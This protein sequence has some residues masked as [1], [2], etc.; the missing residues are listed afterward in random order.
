MASGEDKLESFFREA[1]KTHPL[2]RL[3]N[4]LDNE[5]AGAVFVRN[6]ESGL[7]W[8][9]KDQLLR[10][11]W[12]RITDPKNLGALEREYKE[13]GNMN[14]F[15]TRARIWALATCRRRARGK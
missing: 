7:P 13:T 4:E 1:E 3:W 2:V 6:D 12:L 11:V 10:D 8:R 5:L 14:K 9:T 15:A